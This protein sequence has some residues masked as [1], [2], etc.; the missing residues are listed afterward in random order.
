MKSKHIKETY[1]Q[2]PDY[3]IFKVLWSGK[4]TEN[5]FDRFV[6]NNDKEF[7]YF[8][9]L[10]QN[11]YGDYYNE[12]LWG[13]CLADEFHVSPTKVDKINQYL[14]THNY[15]LNCFGYNTILYIDDFDSL[16]HSEKWQ[17]N[18]LP[19]EEIINDILEILWEEDN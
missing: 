16:I 15:P 13:K 6:I 11:E 1:L 19:L 4:A 17:N 3:P 14:K 7:I 10:Q 12:N 8:K 2:N 18:I 9:S 5:Y